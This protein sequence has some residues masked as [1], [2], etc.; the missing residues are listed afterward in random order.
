MKIDVSSLLC[1]KLFFLVKTNEQVIDKQMKQLAL[2]HT[3]WKIL[4]RFNF[5]PNPCTQQQLLKS[6]DIDPAHLTRVI[7]QLE[8]RKLVV[9]ARSPNDKR[10]FNVCPTPQGKKM[11]ARMEQIMKQ[12]SDVLVEELNENEVKLLNNLLQKI[13]TSALNRLDEKHKH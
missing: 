10:V 12:G 8:Q 2:S 7:D 9:R 6:L 4:I 5:L 11:L 1:Y 3:Q 13:T